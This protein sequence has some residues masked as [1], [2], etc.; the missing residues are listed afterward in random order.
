MQNF[1][2]WLAHYLQSD[3]ILATSDEEEAIS[4]RDFVDQKINEGLEQEARNNL[5]QAIICYLEVLNVDLS[6]DRAHEALAR[7]FTKQ[8]KLSEAQFHL[9]QAVELKLEQT[10][11]SN[12]DLSD[13]KLVKKPDLSLGEDISLSKQQIDLPSKTEL[14]EQPH[15]ATQI[16]K[17]SNKNIILAD[18]DYLSIALNSERARE[19]DRSD[20]EKVVRVLLE[21]A[22][23]FYEDRQ[24]SRAI[25]TC[26]KVLE[27]DANSAEAHKIWGNCL[28]QQNQSTE[29][30]EH[31]AL[32]L[33]LDPDLVEV[34]VNIGTI[35]AKRSKWDKALDYYTQALKI[36]PRCA[37]VHRNLARLWSQLNNSDKAEEHLFKAINLEPKIFSAEQYL[38]LAQELMNEGKE[39]MAI[40]CCCHAIRLEPKFHEAYMQ[41]MDIIEKSDSQTIPYYQQLLKLKDEV[42]REKIRASNRIDN[43][44]TSNGTKGSTASRDNNLGANPIQTLALSRSPTSTQA[45]I[46]SES[47]KSKKSQQT[48]ADSVEALLLAGNKYAL[49]QQWKKAIY[50]F[51]RA[52]KQKPDCAIAYHQLADI[53]RQINDTEAFITCIYRFCVLKPGSVSAKNHFDLGNLLLERDKIAEATVCFRKALELEPKFTQAQDKLREITARDE[54]Q[55][56]K[57]DRS[58]TDGNI[59]LVDRAIANN[60]QNDTTESNKLEADNSEKLTEITG[61]GGENY[62]K[63]IEQSDRESLYYKSL[64]LDSNNVAAYI[65]LAEINAA[66]G[67]QDL[68]I[69]FYEIALEIE[70]NS[71]EILTALEKLKSE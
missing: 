60:T 40:S 42:V 20:L 41:L 9:E 57:N 23:L 52:I 33:E 54:H 46:S 47:I 53:Y 66:R 12:L 4:I 51:A 50:C 7:V 14:E 62:D 39:A 21:Q 58:I 68:A 11:G 25:A 6:C 28:E 19:K 16:V 44:L 5:T 30:I 22:L 24:W 67:H 70:P 29:A 64:E 15:Q 2:S 31:Y 18:A 65:G 27:K 43:L 48:R 3:E 1:I 63:T 13:E 45:V 69:S 38:E 55:S 34:Y 35:F 10:L 26:R 59:E 61:V 17:Q 32:A 49:K 56:I 37:G 8:G 71:Q 36:D